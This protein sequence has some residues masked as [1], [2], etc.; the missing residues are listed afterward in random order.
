MLSALFSTLQSSLGLSKNFLI[1]Y[2]LP[3]LIF[4][5]GSVLITYEIHDPWDLLK[6]NPDKEG[7]WFVLGTIV[8][9]SAVAYVFSSLSVPMREILEGKRILSHRWL[10]KD[11]HRTQQKE[12]DGLSRRFR[13]SGQGLARLCI[14]KW[15][16][17]LKEAVGEG[18]KT[19]Q[20]TY[21]TEGSYAGLERLSQLRMDGKMLDYEE[22]DQ[23]VLAFCRILRVNSLR[24]SASTTLREDYRRLREILEYAQDSLAWEQKRLFN[25][26]QFHYPGLFV[27]RSAGESSA[28]SNV[29]APTDM[30]NIA[31]TVRS[32]ALNRYSL[33][34]DV[35]WS[36][37][38]PV[39]QQNKEF[40]STLQESKTQLDFAI[41]LCW[42]T[43]VFWI[44]WAILLPLY[45]KAY[46]LFGLLM[47]IAPV[48]A[49]VWYRLACE[50]YMTFADLMRT[51]VDLYRFDLID[52]LNL[53]R[54]RDLHDE[55]ILWGRIAQSIGFGDPA[56]DQFDYKAGKK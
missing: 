23:A 34:L 22:L 13:D 56:S 43:I 37:L 42:L 11:L 27:E 29:L 51:S 32:Y 26:R 47:A 6:H 31:R 2:L 49:W 28:T 1:G 50:S 41:S 12:L 24:T 46:L 36:R 15:K 25:W 19:C 52:S 21:P 35:L 10:V 14:G 8:G 9:L 33:D 5:A 40:Y 18:L 44:V 54:P 53:E 17:R 45:S 39:V 4:F 7:T 30:G 48:L 20:C 16:I 3:W 38:Q 55:N